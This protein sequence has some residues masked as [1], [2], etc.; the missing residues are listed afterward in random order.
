MAAEI[1]VEERGRKRQQGCDGHNTPEDTFR[2]GQFK[3]PFHMRNSRERVESL[4]SP[5]TPSNQHQDL[6]RLNEAPPGD[7][8]HHYEHRPGERRCPGCIRLRH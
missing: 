1:A 3:D 5:G 6:G 8:E 4:P 7:R 2:G